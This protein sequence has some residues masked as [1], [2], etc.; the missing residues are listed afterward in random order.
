MNL[1]V[2]LPPRDESVRGGP[3]VMNL[4]VGLPP[5]DESVRWGPTHHASGR[6]KSA[7]GEGSPT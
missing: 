5:R 4:A 1:V 7:R 2:E 6:G 3:P